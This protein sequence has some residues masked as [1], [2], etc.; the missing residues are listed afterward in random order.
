MDGGNVTTTR[1]A[2]SG[3]WH[4][5]YYSPLFNMLL[6]NRLIHR[7]DFFHHQWKDNVANTLHPVSWPGPPPGRRQKVITDERTDHGCLSMRIMSCAT[8]FLDPFIS[9][10]LLAPLSSPHSIFIHPHFPLTS[11]RNFSPT[12][13]LFGLICWAY[14]AGPC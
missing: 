1:T 12:V 2:R 5:P 7:V 11:I 3:K 10:R 13:L 6:R 4:V 8:G 9:F 14:P